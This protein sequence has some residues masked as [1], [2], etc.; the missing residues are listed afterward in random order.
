MP[1]YNQFKSFPQAETVL[2]R[3]IHDL[4]KLKTLVD[5]ENAF[6]RKELSDLQKKFKDKSQEIKVCGLV[7]GF[8][9]P[10]L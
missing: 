8:T 4:V 9:V 5:E 7:H 1:A 10:G 6:L 2:K 3:E